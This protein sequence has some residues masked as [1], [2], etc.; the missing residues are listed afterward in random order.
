MEI[1]RSYLS[2][3]NDDIEYENVSFSVILVT[4]VK[5]PTIF[6]DF[7]ALAFHQNID[8]KEHLVIVK[9]DVVGKENVLVRV[10]SECLTG[11]TI[12]SLRC[13]CR[14]QLEGGLKKIEDEGEGIVI[15]LRQEGRGIGLINKLR[16]YKL[17][18]EGMNT[19]DA[20]LALGLPDDSREYVIASQIIKLLNIGSIRLLTN[21]LNKVSQLERNGIVVSE[22]LRHVFPSNKHNE[23]YLQTKKD[24]SKHLI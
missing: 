7:I 20:N 11:D 3:I 18:D 5:L 19:V 10:H 17:Q 24:I 16:A 13:D 23:Y 22:R 6:G 8:N 9:G 4:A 12:G 14:E 21:N 15:Y 1:P 2:L